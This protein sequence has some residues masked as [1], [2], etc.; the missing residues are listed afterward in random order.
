MDFH[1]HVDRMQKRKDDDLSFKAQ[2]LDH[3]HQTLELARRRNSIERAQRK[4]SIRQQRQRVV[5]QNVMSREQ[6]KHH[7]SKLFEIYSR[8]QGAQLQARDQRVSDLYQAKRKAKQREVHDYT[9]RLVNVRKSCEEQSI[10][11][12]NMCDAY[13]ARLQDLEVAEKQMLD[14]LSHTMRQNQVLVENL[15]RRSVTL[16]NSLLPRNAIAAPKGPRLP[17]HSQYTRDKAER[18]DAKQEYQCKLAERLQ[19][20]QI[21]T[22]DYQ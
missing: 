6:K 8:E 5:L 1:D 14:T 15:S 4:A 12:L 21:P 9:S 7:A 22:P 10:A 17:G 18:G 13:D 16:T 19:R 2:W 11:S 20:A 3:Q